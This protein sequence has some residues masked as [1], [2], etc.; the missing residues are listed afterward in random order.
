MPQLTLLNGS[1]YGRVTLLPANQVCR[2][3]RDPALD[4]CLDDPKASR[5][6]VEIFCENEQWMLKDL[7]SKNGTYVNGQQ[8]SRVLLNDG[9]E[10]Q[11]GETRMAFQLKE[12]PR[13]GYVPDDSMLAPRL[14]VGAE[15]AVGTAGVRG[16]E[17]GFETIELTAPLSTLA[18]DAKG[19]PARK[20]VAER[21]ETPDSPS[22]AARSLRALYSIARASAEATTSA[23][24]L[25]YLAVR[26]R[27]ALDADRVT[28]LVMED[29]KWRVA[30]VDPT[31]VIAETG[32]S[33]PAFSK[34]PL[35]RTIVDY[36]MRCGKAVLTS[37]RADERFAGA[38]SVGEQGISSAVC[39][40]ICANGQ[41]LGFIYADRLGGQDFDRADQELVIAACLQAGPALSSLQRLEQALTRKDRLVAELRSQF[42]MVGDGPAM[43]EV[44]GFIGRA[45]PTESVVLVLGESGTGKELVARAIHYDSTRKDAPLIVVNC[46]ALSESLIESELFGHTRGA[47]TGATCDRPGRFELAHEGTLFL[48]EIGE[49]SNA[50]QTKLLRV[51]E[52]GELSRVGEARV[53]KVNVRLI[54]ATNRD[55]ASE[56]KGGRFREDLY[57]RI[58]VL[59]IKLPPLRE[60]GE[61]I[62]KLAEFYLRDAAERSGRK[63]LHFSDEALAALAH[64]RWPGNVRE[65]RNM[66]ERLAVLCP[67]EAIG[68]RD[69]PPEIA[70]LQAHLPAATAE[71]LS[72]APAA[73]PVAS[74]T[75]SEMEREH[76]LRILNSC[77]GNKKRAAEVLGVDRS[78]LYA[79]L[80]AYGVLGN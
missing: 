39:A 16:G 22:R 55:L 67:T 60:R 26:L 8:V 41:C 36:A 69:L 30:D 7:N 19:V 40:P 17:G 23:V 52:Q 56:V 2:L 80:R 71:T 33:T 78:T 6:H 79:K 68:V 27:T 24:L 25:S 64:H 49:L 15:P 44:Y 70:A 34:V 38:R 62:R 32:R 74:K 66:A 61:D 20:E 77:G 29:G 58:N 75:L 63:H 65:L 76:I 9:D 14:P 28:P 5:V 59:S 18:I 47:F 53:R 35:S 45:A 1:D 3:G 54:A 73:A 57:Y 12:P 4:V 11:I 21:F 42:R 10:V 43:R 50:C 46:A 48:D 13:E 37:P 51:I 72:E 31:T